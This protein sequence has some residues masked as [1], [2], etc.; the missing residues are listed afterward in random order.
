MVWVAEWAVRLSERSYRD[1]RR[2]SWNATTIHRVS[3]PAVQERSLLGATPAHSAKGHAQP[4]EA[5]LL[6]ARRDAMLPGHAGLRGCRTHRRHPG[7]E[8]LYSGSC[9]IFRV[10]RNDEFAAG[11]RRSAAGCLELAERARREVHAGAGQP[12][13]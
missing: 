13:D 4:K 7:P 6:H 3:L 11:T 12:V 9:R 8:S 10:P 2:R 1:R 5:S